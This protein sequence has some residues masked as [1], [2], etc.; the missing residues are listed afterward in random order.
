MAMGKN[1]EIARAIKAAEFALQDGAT[2]K[3]VIFEILRHLHK[4]TL[5]SEGQI[6]DLLNRHRIDVRKMLD[7]EE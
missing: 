6:S 7:G 3:Q 1:A 2:L 4:N 5:I